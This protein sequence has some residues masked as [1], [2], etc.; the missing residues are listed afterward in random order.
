MREL[1]TDDMGTVG[2]FLTDAGISI[3]QNAPGMALAALG[4]L[5]AAAGAAYMGTSA[6]GSKAYEVQ[7]NG[8]SANEA[9]TRGIVSGLIEV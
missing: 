7:A 4:P 3:A 6:A 5:G 9:L 8:G 1:A 2:K